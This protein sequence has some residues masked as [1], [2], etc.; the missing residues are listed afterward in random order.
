MFNASK[1]I[2]LTLIFCFSGF[3]YSDTYDFGSS[4]W[5]DDYAGDTEAY[6]GVYSYKIFQDGVQIIEVIDAATPTISD[7][8]TAPNGAVLTVQMRNSNSLIPAG[9]PLRNGPWTEQIPATASGM[10]TPVTTWTIRV[11]H[12]P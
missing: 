5:V 4:Y 12:G 2:F 7:V 1:C 10:P 9:D 8:V 3:V 11:I 6:S